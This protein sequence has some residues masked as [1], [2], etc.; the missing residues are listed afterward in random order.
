MNF[1]IEKDVPLSESSKGKKNA[2]PLRA[3]D[4]GDSF[5]VPAN[6]SDVSVLRNR[7]AASVRYVSMQN[8]WKFSVRKVEGGLRVWRT[9]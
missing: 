8:G 2:Y 7:L 4:V 3:M 1:E 5:L 6:G 9:E